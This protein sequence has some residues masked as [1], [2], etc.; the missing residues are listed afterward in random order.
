MAAVAGKK[1]AI[2]YRRAELTATT[3]S[4]HDTGPDTIRDSSGQ[5][6]IKGFRAGDYI[7][8]AG[9]VSNDGIYL[10]ATVAAGVI[11]LDAGEA[12]TNEGS[13]TSIT[14]AQRVPGTALV[15]FKD[16]TLDSVGDAYDVTTFAEEGE[17]IYIA[18]NQRWSGSAARYFLSDVNYDDWIGDILLIRFFVH[19]EESP[20]VN[21]AYY[22][23]GLA[24]VTGIS[25]STP[26]NAPVEQELTFQGTGRLSFFTRDMTWSSS[27]HSS[28][29]SCS[30]SHSSC[31][32]SS[33]S[34]SSSQSA[35]SESSES[36]ASSESSESSCSSSSAA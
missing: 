31:C 20:G 3:L 6:R 35:S 22:Y 28:G 30:S 2:Y 24:L 23:E 33:A 34:F 36:S 4:F 5:F 16:W 12:L 27:S 15:G 29:S 18:G 25:T 7:A 1:G 8:V 14:I 19:I 10:V 13:G 32:S 17:E 11:T 26:Q 21:P 9:S